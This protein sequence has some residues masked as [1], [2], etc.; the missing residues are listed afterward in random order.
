MLSDA[1][2]DILKIAEDA[3]DGDKAGPKTKVTY[4]MDFRDPR[5]GDVISTLQFK[6]GKP[7]S[8]DK[9]DKIINEMFPL[10][11][12]VL[13]DRVAATVAANLMVQQGIVKR[14]REDV[15]STFEATFIDEPTDVAAAGATGAVRNAAGR[16]TSQ[17][18]LKASL[19]L[20]MKENMLR[21]MTSPVAGSGPGSPLKYR[22]GRLL[23][24][25]EVATVT[26][27]EDTSGTLSIYYRYMVYPYQVFDPKNTRSPD[28]GLAS[29]MRNPQK[30]IG[31]ALQGAARKL[32][33]KRYKVIIRQVY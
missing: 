19:E 16:F 2:Q 25:A 31:D 7:I 29:Y 14:L 8:E 21:T 26:V 3:F 15:D 28:T 18:N 10:I 27:P 17:V 30:L 20:L 33:S 1:A 12:N 22:T 23:S 24:S 11:S 5:S 4:E 13:E 6:L 9:A 32:L